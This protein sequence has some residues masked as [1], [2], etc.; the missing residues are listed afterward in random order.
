MKSMVNKMVN[1]ILLIV[2][3]GGLGIMSTFAMTSPT[4]C[5]YDDIV[6]WVQRL[7][8]PI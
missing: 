1:A 3:S 6:A 2:I 8:N 4:G 7:R 5:L